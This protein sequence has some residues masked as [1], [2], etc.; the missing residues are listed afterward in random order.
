MRRF[1]RNSQTRRDAL[2]SIGHAVFQHMPH[3]SRAR[4]DE[5]VRYSGL[6][7]LPNTSVTPSHA[8]INESAIVAGSC[9]NAPTWTVAGGDIF[10]AD[11][12]TNATKFTALMAG[13]AD[14]G[15]ISSVVSGSDFSLNTARDTLVL[16]LSAA[17][18]TYS[19]GANQSYV[20]TFPE[21]AFRNR[22]GAL[23][24]T[25]AIVVVNS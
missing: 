2:T 22:A 4:R 13:L 18:A 25:S 17:I 10:V 8:L 12:L 7:G 11:I 19:I 14:G 1:P 15:A 23:V 5:D 6:T 16:S 3:D 9:A 24:V 20:W 21:T